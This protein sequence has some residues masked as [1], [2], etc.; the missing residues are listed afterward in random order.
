MRELRVENKYYGVSLPG[1]TRHCFCVPPAHPT[2]SAISPPP[3]HAPFVFAPRTLTVAP[4]HTHTLAPSCLPCLTQTHR[5]AEL[6]EWNDEMRQKGIVTVM[7]GTPDVPDIDM[8][9]NPA[10]MCIE[11]IDDERR[12]SIVGGTPPQ[13]NFSNFLPSRNGRMI[14]QLRPVSK[15]RSMKSN[16]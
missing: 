4:T 12:R 14:Y 15:W 8:T 10:A 1:E 6:V 5:R 7:H 13:G 9:F 16:K 2:H 3:P 11:E